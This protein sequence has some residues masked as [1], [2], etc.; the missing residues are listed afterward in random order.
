MAGYDIIETIKANEKAGNISHS[1]GVRLGRLSLLLCHH[2]YDRYE[3]MEREGVNI[4]ATEL[5]I[6]D[7]DIIEHEYNQKI[8]ALEA[9][10]QKEEQQHLAFKLMLKGFSDKDIQKETGLTAME[11]EELRK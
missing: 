11:L 2:L 10:L 5:L 3:E 9:S 1:E 8:Q 6:L 7:I 4:M